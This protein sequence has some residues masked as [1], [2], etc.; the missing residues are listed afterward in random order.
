[1]RRKQDVPVP[2]RCGMQQNQRAREANLG[3]TP[4]CSSP[5]Y[6]SAVV[7]GRRRRE[8]GNANGKVAERRILPLCQVPKLQSWRS[9]RSMELDE[10]L[11]LHS[12]REP[13]LVREELWRTP[14][15]SW[16]IW[17]LV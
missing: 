8:R 15:P 9:V 14:E 6:R 2:E 17:S 5:K 12:R 1:M 4:S 11:L 13:Q 16:G 3:T 7:R 10:Q